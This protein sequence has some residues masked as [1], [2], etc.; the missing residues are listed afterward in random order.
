[1]S[2]AVHSLTEKPE[3]FDTHSGIGGNFPLDGAVV[4]GLNLGTPGEF[5]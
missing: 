5:S 4:E 2:T 1:M 3:D